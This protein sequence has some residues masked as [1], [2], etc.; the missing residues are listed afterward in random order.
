MKGRA[1]R[2]VRM[3]RGSQRTRALWQRAISV[4]RYAARGEGAAGA[5]GG[6]GGG[7][8]GAGSGGGGGSSSSAGGSMLKNSRTSFHAL[9][10]SLV[11]QKNRCGISL[12]FF[13]FFFFFFLINKTVR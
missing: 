12:F 9:A 11:E 3:E 8:G 13:F 4:S 7:G 5:G 6:G 10:S 1:E 2:A